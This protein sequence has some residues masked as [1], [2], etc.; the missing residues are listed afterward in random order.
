MALK[1]ILAQR[2][3]LI[4]Q[5]AEIDRQI[6]MAEGVEFVTDFSSLLNDVVTGLQAITRAAQTP[7][8]KEE[9]ASVRSR[10]RVALRDQK[11]T[12]DRALDF[13]DKWTMPVS[14]S[15]TVQP[16]IVTPVTE[17]KIDDT[18]VDLVSTENCTSVEG[19]APA[20]TQAGTTT[21]KR[22]EDLMSDALSTTQHRIATKFNE[23][24]KDIVIDDV[25]QEL[26][27]GRIPFNGTE[28][29]WLTNYIK[30]NWGTDFVL[31]GA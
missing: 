1:D 26:R 23:H 19:E 20:S 7:Q 3:Q 6:E 21:D 18:P 10:L 12:I 15:P 4:E 2:Q 29:Q 9:A 30:K 31:K 17:A 14:P 5:I 24:V 27:V 11:I 25:A 22:L 8:T 28:R 16:E 13:I